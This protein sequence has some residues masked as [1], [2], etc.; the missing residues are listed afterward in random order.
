MY[1][2]RV[3]YFESRKKA[4]KMLAK[5]LKPLRFKNTA[6]VA[7]NEGGVAIAEPIAA[8]LHSTIWFLLSRP[9]NLPAAESETIGSVVQDGTFVSDDSLS[10]IE[11]SEIASEFH[12]YID[13]EKLRQLHEM[14][15]LVG[16]TGIVD[17]SVLKGHVVIAVSDGLAG[18]SQLEA[19]ES[20]LKPIKVE[21]LIIAVPLA[22]VKAVDKMHI[23][24]D[25]IYCLNVIDNFLTVDHY[26]NET[27][28]PS[29]EEAMAIVRNAINQ[30]S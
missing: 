4:G 10:D 18:L 24:F 17:P 11:A 16:E 15:R 23:M 8:A 14:N 7:L 1:R 22:T 21:R 9:I 6:I 12:S 27:P 20:F 3:M 29:H 30:W 28:P 25:E 26:Y 5:Q 19:L 2:I 13:E